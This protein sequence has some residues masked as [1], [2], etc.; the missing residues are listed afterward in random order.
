MT[1]FL[2]DPRPRMGLEQSRGD[3]RPARRLRFAAVDLDAA[4]VLGADVA[5]LSRTDQAHR[6][7]VVGADI[8]L[9]VP[10][11]GLVDSATTLRL[12][13][14]L[15]VVALVGLVGALVMAT[16]PV[17]ARVVVPAVTSAALGAGTVIFGTDHPAT[18]ASAPVPGSAVPGW[19]A[20]AWFVALALIALSTSTGP[21]LAGVLVA[22]VALLLALA[23]RTPPTPVA[24]HGPL[25]A[26]MAIV[27]HL[28]PLGRDQQGRPAW[29]NPVVNAAHAA[30]PHPALWLTAVVAGLALAGHAPT[31]PVPTLA[32]ATLGAGAVLRVGIFRPYF[33]GV[34][35]PV[36]AAYGLIAAG[37]WLAPVD[38][39]AFVALH[40][41]AIAVLHRQAIARHDPRTAR[42]VQFLP[43]TAV[44]ISVLTGLWVL[45]T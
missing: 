12:L 19:T 34:L 29:R 24:H 17:D 20:V 28:A 22:H 13:R 14:T 30:L 35:A 11:A 38:L 37:R 4:E 3:E 41:V 32:V 45:A 8:E 7:A 2:P 15:A 44:V 6:R 39:L 26:L 42:A 9:V 5:V 1:L 33:T 10:L 40:A 36:A 31:P 43:R 18:A 16:A 23:R 27:G 25:A 21:V